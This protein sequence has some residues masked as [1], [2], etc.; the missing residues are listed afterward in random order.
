MEYLD[1]IKAASSS[2]TSKV[3][4]SSLQVSFLSAILPAYV[5]SGSYRMS[6]VGWWRNWMPMM[7]STMWVWI[8]VARSRVQEGRVVDLEPSASPS[9]ERP[10]EDLKATSLE[11]L[12]SAHFRGEFQK[13]NGIFWEFFPK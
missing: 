4:T 8:T 13:K 11:R 10:S 12:N 5:F 1:H 3:T 2:F 9:R 7:L 6:S